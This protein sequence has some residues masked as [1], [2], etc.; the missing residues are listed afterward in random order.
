MNKFEFNGNWTPKINLEILTKLGSDYMFNPTHHL[1]WIRNLHAD[2]KNK[3]IQFRIDAARNDNDIPEPD[4]LNAID[5]IL[6]NESK[7]YHQIFTNLK[8]IIYPFYS[9]LFGEDLQLE[10]PLDKIDALPEVLGLIEIQ[11]HQISKNNVAWCTYMFKWKGEQEHGL[12]MLFEGDHFL[13][14]A[15]AGDMWFEDLLPEEELKTLSEAWNKEMPKKLYYPNP[16]LKSYKHW[17][18]EQT[19]SF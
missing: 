12:S 6:N 11:V 9:D 5:F 16:Q 15:P 4:Q 2:H 3:I 7:I 1:K 19:N 10:F 17:Q 8:T 18:L 14:H 13:K